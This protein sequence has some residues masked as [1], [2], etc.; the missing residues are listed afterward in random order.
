M[1]IRR[2]FDNMNAVIKRVFIVQSVFKWS[3]LINPFMNNTLARTLFL[4][5]LY[6]AAH[7]TVVVVF[8][9]FFFSHRRIFAAAFFHD[10][11]VWAVVVR[12]DGRLFPGVRCHR[13]TAVKPAQ[14]WGER[15][16]VLGFDPYVEQLPWNPFATRHF[17]ELAKTVYRVCFAPAVW[18]EP[19]LLAVTRML[20]LYSV[21]RRSI[22][23]SVWLSCPFLDIFS[24]TT[25]R[26]RK[27]RDFCFHF[28]IE[29]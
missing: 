2:R 5:I 24:A 14:A 28:A 26:C 12:V 22:C 7:F 25:W 1:Y 20:L 23:F 3:L 4:H 16:R 19:C 6:H 17:R 27:L 21:Y 18:P 10:S 15:R 8:F 9:L 11:N 29:R 13:E